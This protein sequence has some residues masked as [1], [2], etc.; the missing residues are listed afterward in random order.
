MNNKFNQNIR[1]INRN[2]STWKYVQK[3]AGHQLTV[4]QM[5]FSPDSKHLLTV[6]RDRR[7]CIFENHA[8]ADADETACNFELIATTDKK[9]S[10]HS[11]IIWTCDWAHDGTV[12]ATGS[13]D[14]KA[15]V[16]TLGE[17]S[18]QTSLGTYRALG[19]LDLAKNDSVTAVAFANEYLRQENGN[20][21]IALGL[22]TGFIHLYS[23]DKAWTQLFTIDRS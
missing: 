18:S 13:R 5:K 3:L 20:Y 4:T 16:W 9:N 17:Q 22:E 21:L 15:V 11:R 7:W 2:T 14:A 23:F 1:I 8:A 12:F 10:I 19:T 6:G